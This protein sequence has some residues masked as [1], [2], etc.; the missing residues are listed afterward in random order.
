MNGGTLDRFPTESEYGYDSDTSSA[1]NVDYDI[2]A[3][4]CTGKNPCFVTRSPSA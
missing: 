4:G 1:I 3:D 2:L